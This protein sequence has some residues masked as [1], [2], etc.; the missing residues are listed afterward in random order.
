MTK[1]EA[2]AMLNEA[3]DGN[4]S[5]RANPVLTLTQAKDIVRNGLESLSGYEAAHLSP[6]MEKR[7]YQVVRNQRCP[8]F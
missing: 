6:L 3:P 5:W 1:D 7:V 4:C 8:N 2:L